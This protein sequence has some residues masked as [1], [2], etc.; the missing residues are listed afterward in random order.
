MIEELKSAEPPLSASS[1]SP[2]EEIGMAE[3]LEQESAAQS[4]NQ[5]PIFMAEIV[6]VVKDGVLVD[7]GRKMEA[8]IP[9]EEFGTKFPFKVGEMIPVC[10]VQGNSSD[11]HAKVSW[12]RAQEQ[13]A[14]EEVEQAL[15]TKT[16]LQAKI[17]LEIKGGLVVEC[18]NGLR[19]FLPAS[20]IDVRPV[21]DLKKWMGQKITVYVMDFDAH[22]NNLVLS[23]KLWKSEEDQKKREEIL[24]VLK[25]GDKREGIVRGITSYGAFIDIGGMEALLHIGELD[26]AHTKRVKDVLK[27]GQRI[28]VQVIAIDQESQKIALSRKTLLTH[29][30]EKIEE[31]FPLGSIQDGRVTHL[32]DFGAFVEICPNVEGLAHISEIS[33]S[34]DKK[35]PKEL[36]KAGQKVQVKILA[37]D[38]EKEKISLSIKRAGQSPWEMFPSKYRVGSLVKVRIS[39]LASFGAFASL[40]EGPEGLIHIS[41]FSWTQK[42]ENPKEVLKVGE[43]VEVKVLEIDAKK[44][45]ISFGLKQKESNPFEAIRKR[46]KLKGKVVSIES[47]GAI[48]DLENQL[49]GFIAMAE[50]SSEK[51]VHPT[52]IIK[53]GEEIEAV[54]TDVNAKE[55]RVYLSIKR[56]EHQLQRAAAEKYS[57]KSPGPALGQ[58]FNS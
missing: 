8:L 56:L 40:P 38:R 23:R 25:V 53:V 43:I 47:S 1:D 4:S 29:P 20:Q 27:I 39:S 18:E 2:E 57:K 41:D 13:I 6:S 15:R 10:K 7:T 55:R 14:W 42:I 46:S 16:P 12:K 30:W 28:E 51:F 35:K 5:N 9:M 32:T 52:D 36:L 49:Q 58:L 50:L 44:E 31:R 26:W 33:W 3:L 48:I 45:K 54:V 17:V 22:K 21:R 19:G 34:S 37:I 11:G 24:T